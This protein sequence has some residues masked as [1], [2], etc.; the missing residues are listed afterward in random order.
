VIVLACKFDKLNLS[1]DDISIASEEELLCSIKN[2]KYRAMSAYQLCEIHVRRDNAIGAYTYALHALVTSP[3]AAEGYLCLSKIYLLMGRHIQASFYAQIASNRHRSVAVYEAT[4]NA[5]S[6]LHGFCQ[7]SSLANDINT[8]DCSKVTAVTQDHYQDDWTTDLISRL[9][10][11]SYSLL[12]IYS[13]IA[14]KLPA[15]MTG[16]SVFGYELFLS[17]VMQI[18]ASSSPVPL[19][20][21]SPELFQLSLSHSSDTD[22][23]LQ[24]KLRW[25]KSRT[26]VLYSPVQS[27]FI[28]GENLVGLSDVLNRLGVPHRVSSVVHTHSDYI[29]VEPMAPP[30][31][32]RRAFV[33]WNFE[34]NPALV[35]M[36]SQPTGFGFKDECWREEARYSQEYMAEARQRWESISANMGKWER[37]VRRFNGNAA[38][39]GGSGV[40]GGG[41]TTPKLIKAF[42]PLRHMQF[43]TAELNFRGKLKHCPCTIACYCRG[44]YYYNTRSI[45]IMC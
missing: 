17:H 1:P 43:A 34:K 5:A 2:I 31:Y 11:T 26:L 8:L 6:F 18:C 15:A 45:S 3:H 20:A 40:L 14:H 38:A 44:H 13:A 24:S 27:V 30:S 29:A 25:P 42:M 19:E 36:K 22:S 37:E 23:I 10:E 21:H 7:E 39:S 35:D 4:R 12:E 32:Q 16:P 28:F 41:M 33:A 9:S